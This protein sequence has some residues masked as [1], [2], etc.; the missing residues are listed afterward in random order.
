MGENSVA[1][2]V[3]RKSKVSTVNWTGNVNKETITMIKEIDNV[4]LNIIS[5]QIMDL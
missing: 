4:L 5:G 3:E 1:F 2:L